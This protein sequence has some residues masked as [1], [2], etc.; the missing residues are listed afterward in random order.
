L[1]ALAIR[2]PE[3]FGLELV[4]LVDENW[5]TGADSTSL[6]SA[7]VESLI[8]R[9][10]DS[11]GPRA[12]N[13]VW[14]ALR[15]SKTFAPAMEMLF[16]LSTRVGNPLNADWLYNLLVTTPM[17]DRDAFLSPYLHNTYGQQ[18]G[19][20]R[21]IGW[22]LK[23]D[24]EAIS[25]KVTELWAV[26]LCW[27]CSASDRRVRD[28]ATKALVRLMEVHVSRW[29]NIISRA[30]WIDDEYVV[31]RCLAAA[32]GSL[33]RADRDDAL[34]KTALVVYKTFFENGSLPQNAMVRDYARSIL[35]LAARR[36][37]LPKHLTP[38]Q[39]RPPYESE[40]PLDWPDK[41][42]VEQYSDSYQ[43]LPKLY[44]SCLHDDF[45][46]YTV[47]Y[48]LRG[49][50]DIDP[51]QAR[52][53]IFKHV[54]DIGYTTGRF[55]GFDGNML[56]E[57]GPG[58]SKPA[59]AERIG[60]KYQWIA[61]YRL[62][63]RVADH[64]EKN[65]HR[66]TPSVPELQALGQ[67]KIDPTVLIKEDQ[68]SDVVTWWAPVDYDFRSVEALSDDDWLDEKDFPDSAD[69]LQVEDPKSSTEWIVLRASMRWRST[70]EDSQEKYPYREIR[71]QLQSYL[72]QRADQVECWN[73][74]KDQD[75]MERWMP[76]GFDMHEGFLG[77]YPWGL[78][79]VHY[80]EQV[81]LERPYD[82]GI[83]PQRPCKMLPTAHSLR[84]GS[85]Y[86]AYQE[87]NIAIMV[88]TEKFFTHSSL[89]WDTKGGYLIDSGKLCFNYPTA[90]HPGPAALLAEREH[91]LSFLEE[92]DLVLAWAVLAEKQ[93]IHGF[94]S[95]HELRY[96]K[97]SRAH[98]LV[99]SDVR[100]TDGIT[101][102]VKPERPD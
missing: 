98:M 97:H 20:D 42:F 73:W 34:A 27:F 1:D 47:E 31:E 54:L 80:F 36:T 94:G 26:Q 40:W 93:C 91:L 60:K 41:D 55:A 50:E 69:M 21:L 23:A 7:V 96:A 3:R 18:K 39:F 15:D 37:L 61:L 10:D 90:S 82:D 58:R 25:S 86:D 99:D 12:Q 76:E 28:Y 92:E 8:W 89:R 81:A 29:P 43:E 45:A 38:D 48:A 9:A 79:F 72:V 95:S 11:V 24:I 102:R 19:L 2:I 66:W 22:A 100:S 65:T 52:R 53:W 33:V 63:A 32:Y 57:Y 56:A 16:A 75:F 67:R 44:K 4:D 14:S 87:D 64:C 5:L 6:T 62:I 83:N 78:P 17:P 71:I 101:E 88:P 59:W 77:E 13:I 51:P 49:Y 35:E 85:E 84:S 46:R 30:R 70:G 68:R 74:L